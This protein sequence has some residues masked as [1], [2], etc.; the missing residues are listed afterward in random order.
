MA[1]DNLILL[2]DW[3]KCGGYFYWIHIRQERFIVAGIGH[4]SIVGVRYCF[5]W[6]PVVAQPTLRQSWSQA[7]IILAGIM[8]NDL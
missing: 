3:G 7:E 5:L 2:K 1:G 8:I 6:C 4:M